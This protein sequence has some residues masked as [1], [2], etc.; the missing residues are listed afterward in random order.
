MHTDKHGYVLGR[1]RRGHSA[2][3]SFAGAVS[4]ICPTCSR[5]LKAA[6]HC[7]TPK[8]CRAELGAGNRGNVLECGSAVP[9]W[10]EFADATL[11]PDSRK[12]PP[13]GIGGCC[14]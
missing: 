8:R 10:S 1:N 13:P 5:R 4:M 7:R 9:L 12:S 6:Q 2:L 3:N 11:E 14:V